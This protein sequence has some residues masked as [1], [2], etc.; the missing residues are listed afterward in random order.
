MVHSSVEYGGDIDNHVAYLLIHIVASIQIS[1][2]LQP[3]NTCSIL[4]LQEIVYNVHFYARNIVE[5]LP[6]RWINAA[7]NVGWILKQILETQSFYGI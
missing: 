5:E 2:K 6:K 3:A 7:K 1:E 4:Y